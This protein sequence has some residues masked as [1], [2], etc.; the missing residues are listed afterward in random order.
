M[1]I[2]FLKGHYS[3]VTSFW[4]ILWA[5]NILLFLCLIG[6]LSFTENKL[7]ILSLTLIY[8]IFIIITLVG[9]WNSASRY[10]EDKKKNKQSPLWGYAAKTYLVVIILWQII[11]RFILPLF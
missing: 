9:T 3:L 10:S 4:G 6:I 2:K 7:I 11:K 5:L 8:L 1:I